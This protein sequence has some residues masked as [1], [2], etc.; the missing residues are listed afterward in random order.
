MTTTLTSDDTLTTEDPVA[1]A[2]TV[3][4][5]DGPDAGAVTTGAELV[6]EDLLV[7]DVSIDGMCGVY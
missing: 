2:G 4:L 7:E 3:G 1:S 6:E 5:V